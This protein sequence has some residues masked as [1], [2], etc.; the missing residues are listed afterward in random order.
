MSRQLRWRAG[1]GVRGTRSRR[2]TR[3]VGQRRADP[4]PGRGGLGGVFG[5]RSWLSRPGRQ[6]PSPVRVKQNQFCRRVHRLEPPSRGQA[7]LRG[8]A[9]GPPRLVGP[10]RRRPRRL[11]QRG[12]GQIPDPLQWERAGRARHGGQAGEETLPGVGRHKGSRRRRDGHLSPPAINTRRVSR[13][14]D[15]LGSSGVAFTNWEQAAISAL[16]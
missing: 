15:A 14:D 11:G 10:P 3:R 6:G 16:L 5:S 8:R 7:R 1:S 4:G 12:P 13:K 9:C 2:P